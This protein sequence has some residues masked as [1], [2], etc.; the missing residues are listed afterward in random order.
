MEKRIHTVQRW[1]DRCLLA[2]RSRSWENA[3]S[4]MECAAAE[5]ENARRVLWSVVD[6]PHTFSRRR[7]TRSVGTVLAATVFVLMAAFPL[8][9]SD[10]RGEALLWQDQKALLELVTLDERKLLRALRN[11]LSGANLV[12]VPSSVSEPPK[13]FQR[14]R[15]RV[16]RSEELPSMPKSTSSQRTVPLDE[17][18]SLI[19]IGQRALRGG[20]SLVILEDTNEL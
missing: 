15:H 7:G 11:N 4:D 14:Q 12:E 10:L 1:L 3:L 17:M 20:D 5:L 8:S 9:T 13:E 16:S 18:M 6:Q 2:C 19:E